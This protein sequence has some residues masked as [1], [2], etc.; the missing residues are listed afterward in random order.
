MFQFSQDQCIKHIRLCVFAKVN[1]IKKLTTW[2]QIQLNEGSKEEI[3]GPVLSTLVC[4]CVCCLF[5]IQWTLYIFV[6]MKSV[7]W[8]ENEAHFS[9]NFQNSIVYKASESRR[10]LGWY[11]C[12][13]QNANEENELK[14]LFW[15]SNSCSFSLNDWCKKR[16][17]NIFTRI[18]SFPLH[19]FV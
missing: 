17:N 7:D 6:K 4:S 13:L 19:K 9:E 18:S 5:I 1:G 15:L 16:K 2:N 14:I 8:V 12:Q 10:K 3:D 11:C